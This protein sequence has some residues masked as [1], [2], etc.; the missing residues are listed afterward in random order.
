VQWEGTVVKVTGDKFVARLTDLNGAESPEKR[1]TISIDQ[2]SESDQMLVLAGAVFYWTIGY[3]VEEHGQKS[4]V[5]TIRF[6]RLPTWTR[7]EI[8][9]AKQLGSQFDALFRADD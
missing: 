3:R 2:I 6:R 1:A 8:E 9:R 7:S 5:S 4:L